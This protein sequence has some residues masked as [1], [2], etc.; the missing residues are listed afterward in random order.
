MDPKDI[1]LDRQVA[2]QVMGLTVV[3]DPTTYRGV[4]VGEAGSR[5]EDLSHYSTQMEEAMKVVDQMRKSGHRW[6]INIDTEGYHL[7]RVVFVAHNGERDEKTYTVDRPLGT[8]KGIEDLPRV[9]CQAALKEHEEAL[10][11]VSGK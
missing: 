10:K 8:T 9:I 7:R 4:S 1:K 11:E 3:S 5:G 2:E 6:L